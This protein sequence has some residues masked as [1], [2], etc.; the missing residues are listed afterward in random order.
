MVEVCLSWYE[1]MLGGNTGVARAVSAMRDK[2][3][4]EEKRTDDSIERHIHGAISELAVAKA[5]GIYWSPAVGRTDT[6]VGDIAGKFHVKSITNKNHCCIIR[7]N[8]PPE[9]PYVLVLLDLP[10]TYLMGWIEGTEGKNPIFWREANSTNTL[11][12][13]A[14]FVPQRALKPMSQL[15]NPKNGV[16]FALQYRAS[17]QL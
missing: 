4:L 8:D 2:R 11:H 12:T 17:L 14:F 10:M 15:T 6:E 5:F 16:D 9:F 13:S 3:K 7:P 1:I